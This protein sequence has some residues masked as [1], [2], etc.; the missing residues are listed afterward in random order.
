MELRQ[1]R[2]FVA[3]AETLNFGRAAAT[4]NMSQPPLSRQIKAFEAELGT[5]LFNR[6]TRGVRLS[7]AGVALLGEARRL[8]RD[9]DAIAAG[10][11]ALGRGEMGTVRLGFISTAAYNV[12][13][14]VLPDFHRR[15]PAV[16]LHLQEATSDAQTAMLR[17]DELDVGVVIPPVRGAD[18]S[19][20]ALLRE[21]LMAAL[22][23]R[24][25]WPRRVI[26]AT[27]AR[28]SFVLFPR[29]A[30]AGLYDLIV[31]H[32]R[33]AGFTPRIEQEAIQMSTIVSLVAAGM[34]VAIVP[35]SLRHMRRAG[36]VYR[37]LGEPVPMM[38]LGVAWRRVQAEPAVTAFIDHVSATYA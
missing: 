10:A 34:G 24:R 30:A 20:R 12:L 27:L 4:L 3:V 26:L 31:G 25:R 9:A 29:K 7:A 1:L 18:L 28:E 23:A 36:V 19:Y 13:P 11:Y 5:T 17:T 14:R 21:P 22:P 32:C 35:A 15:R 2:Y 6:T 38:E 33:D 8:L 37:S 16:R